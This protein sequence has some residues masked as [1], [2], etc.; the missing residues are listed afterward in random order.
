[1]GRSVLK[2][3]CASVGGI[4]G[5][6]PPASRWCLA[7]ALMLPTPGMAAGSD[8]AEA[9]GAQQSVTT[10]GTLLDGQPTDPNRPTLTIATSS[11]QG[12]TVLQPTIQIAPGKRR[13]A[14]DAVLSLQ[15]PALQWDGKI[16]TVETIGLNWE[17]RW[18]A[19]DGRL[20][21]FA[22]YLSAVIDYSRAKAGVS[23]DATMIIAKTVGQTVLYANAFVSFDKAPDSAAIWTPG[24]VFGLKLPARDENAFVLDIVVARSAPALLEFGYQLDAPDDFNIGPGFSVSLEKRPQLTIGLTIQRE[25]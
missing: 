12:V 22:T 24:L 8:C 25:F 15:I 1:M 6:V 7:A 19:D 2:I 16:R 3:I 20:P 17:Q 21:T 23:L 14:C 9:V 18:H 10:F 11:S 5:R 13:G 4:G